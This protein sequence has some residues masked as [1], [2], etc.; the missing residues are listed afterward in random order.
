MK[1]MQYYH[2]PLFACFAEICIVQEIFREK[3]EL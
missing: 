2:T 3:N 1:I